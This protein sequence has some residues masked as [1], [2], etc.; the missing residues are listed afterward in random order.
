M[1]SLDDIPFVPREAIL[2]CYLGT[3][4]QSSFELPDDRGEAVA[5]MSK[6]LTCFLNKTYEEGILLGAIGL[7]GSGGTALLSPAFGSLP[8]GV[9]KLIVSTVASGQTQPYI[10]TSDLVLFPSVVDICGVN[11]VSRVILSN[12][13][14]AFAGMV[15]GK[16]LASDESSEMSKRPTVGLTMFGVTTP[17]VNAVKERLRQEGYETLVFHAT[18]VGGKAMEELVRG[19]YIQVSLTTIFSFYSEGNV[20]QRI[21][22]LLSRYVNLDIVFYLGSVWL[23]WS[24]GISVVLQY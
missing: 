7:G 12:A 4:E 20:L 21:L 15:V 3:V 24:F 8:L 19:G 22:F 18:G 2:S 11:N 14:A 5:V 13:G 6:A 10:G 16:L 23:D 9:P 17:C 1:P